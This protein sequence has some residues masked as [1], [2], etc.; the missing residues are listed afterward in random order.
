MRNIL[1]I[2]RENIILG[3]QIETI[4]ERIAIKQEKRAKNRIKY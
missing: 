4:Y 1:N 3:K 2:A